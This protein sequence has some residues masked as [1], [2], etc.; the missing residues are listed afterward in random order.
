MCVGVD[1]GWGGERRRG[2]AM[3]WILFFGRRN[4]EGKT[5]GRVLRILLML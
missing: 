2:K 5:L 4:E 1:M 3:A